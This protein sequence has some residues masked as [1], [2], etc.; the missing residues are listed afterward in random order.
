MF[1]MLS[2]LPIKFEVLSLSAIAVISLFWIV[3]NMALEEDKQ[4]LL[5]E[6]QVDQTMAEQ[7]FLHEEAHDTQVEDSKSDEEVAIDTKAPDCSTDDMCEIK[8]LADSAHSK[9]EF[10]DAEVAISDDAEKHTERDEQVSATPQ[11]NSDDI[12]SRASTD[13][14]S[15]HEP[16]ATYEAKVKSF[17]HTLWPQMRSDEI[18]IERMKGGSDNRIV[19]IELKPRQS[20]L[21]RV[22]RRVRNY[23][24]RKKVSA[25]ASTKYILRIPRFIG[26]RD[27]TEDIALLEF[28]RGLDV[29]VPTVV[30]ADYTST[31]ILG[32]PYVLQKR[33]DGQPLDKLWDDLNRKQ[34][35]CIVK[36]IAEI[37]VKLSAKRSKTCGRIGNGSITGGKAWLKQD[38]GPQVVVPSFMEHADCDAVDL[39][40]SYWQNPPRTMIPATL[41]EWENYEPYCMPWPEL[42]DLA[43]AVDKSSNVWD[44]D[45]Y[46]F[47]H[48]DLW[49]RNMLAEVTGEDSARVTAILDWD[50]ASFAPA[51]VACLPP[52]WMWQWDEYCRVDKDRLEEY[53]MDKIAAHAPTDAASKEIK[54]LFD[55][56]VGTEITRHMYNVSGNLARRMYPW[57]VEG[58]RGCAWHGEVAFQMID[59]WEAEH[60]AG[61]AEAAESDTEDEDEIEDEDEDEDED[62]EAQ[63]VDA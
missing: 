31:N 38:A 30:K 41:R 51:V 19:G 43:E 52:V 17:C 27:L 44:E 4:P 3:A 63:Y 35:L 5:A 54:A 25:I 45:D 57:V 29:P 37:L 21:P 59:E 32:K 16:W 34:R 46:W 61:E 7:S 22:L 48:G 42:A 1:D 60:P 58:I 23:A 33:I 24:S 2:R 55:R 62:E 18:L 9:Q 28:V 39:G 13:K 56:T 12:V 14:F 40:K 26:E 11:E 15:E 8:S 36:Q 10:H 47:T 20:L 53:D 6:E 50:L 49:P